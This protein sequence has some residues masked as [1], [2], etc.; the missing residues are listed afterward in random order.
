MKTKILSVIVLC[1]VAFSINANA[2]SKSNFFLGKWE[3]LVTGLPDG[4]MTF[5]VSLEQ[6]EKGTL[7]GI[8]GKTMPITNIE[9]GDGNITLYFTG[10]GNEVYLY[11][12]KKGDNKVVGNM[13]DMF[14][15][16][17]KR[18]IEKKKDSKEKK[19]E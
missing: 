2:Q 1:L 19:N 5:L 6:D 9:L 14:D 13:M 12:E 8:I 16:E 15:A 18:V 7:K 11:L 3:V 4:D 17:G 10:Q